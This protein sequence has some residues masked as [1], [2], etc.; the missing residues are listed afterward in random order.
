MELYRLTDDPGEKKNLFGKADVAADQQKMLD[1]LN[2]FTE[3]KLA[4]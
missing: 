2:E 3:V 4:Q 1:L